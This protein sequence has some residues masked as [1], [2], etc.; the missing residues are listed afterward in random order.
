MIREARSLGLGRLITDEMIDDLLDET[1][2][3]SDYMIL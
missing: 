3:Y 1:I 2:W